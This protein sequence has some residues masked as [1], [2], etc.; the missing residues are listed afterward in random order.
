MAPAPF[1][2]NKPQARV[3][4]EVVVAEE[5]IHLPG[6]LVEIVGMEMSCQG[7]LCEEHNQCG[8]MLREDVVVH[9]RRVQLMVEGKE[10][11]MVAAVWVSDGINHCCVGFLHC[12]MVPHAALYNGALAQVT[13]VFNKI[14]DECNSAERHMYYINKGYLHV[15]IISYLM[16]A[17]CIG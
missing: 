14:P 3:P 9:L 17:A 16:R 13:R 12:H 15:V 2:L 5:P 10:E 1:P 4:A 7:H 8:E 11:R 6:I